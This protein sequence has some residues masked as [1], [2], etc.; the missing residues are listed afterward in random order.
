MSIFSKMMRIS[1][2]F[3]D[4]NGVGRAK[5]I[6]VDKDGRLSTF[7]ERA[8]VNLQ[9]GQSIPLPANSFVELMDSALEQDV[10]NFKTIRIGL[11]LSSANR[12]INVRWDFRSEN[13]DT[14][15]FRQHDPMIITADRN[16]YAESDVYGSKI[17]TLRIYNT[18]EN[19]TTIVSYEILGVR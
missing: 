16:Y 7:P 11:R 10:G 18:Q 3:I 4:E 12:E 19:D 5:A 9:E 15:V 13:D 8:V 6:K 14:E 17:R 2:R 1:G